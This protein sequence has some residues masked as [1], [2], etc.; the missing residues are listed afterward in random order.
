[1]TTF[2]GGGGVS[3]NFAATGLGADLAVLAGGAGRAAGVG[4]GLGSGSG[5]MGAGVLGAVFGTVFAGSLLRGALGG[6]ECGTVATAAGARGLL[7]GFDAVCACVGTGCSRFVKSAGLGRLIPT[8]PGDVSD[9]MV[10]GEPLS[11]V[12]TGRMGSTVLGFP[13]TLLE[14]PITTASRTGTGGVG[15]LGLGGILT[16]SV[17]SS[18]LGFRERLLGDFGI[19]IPSSRSRIRVSLAEK[20]LAFSRAIAR[21]DASLGIRNGA[22]TCSPTKGV[23]NLPI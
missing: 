19:E 7:W 22:R 4:A 20:S 10:A 13:S 18:P 21:A 15:T 6:A 5:L 2:P 3:G 8:L 17:K 12:T 14:L 11:L 16:D 23:S 9:L 1:M